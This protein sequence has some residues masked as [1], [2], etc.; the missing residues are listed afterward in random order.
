MIYV[1]IMKQQDD[2]LKSYW[3]SMCGIVVINRN[4]I[5]ISLLQSGSIGGNDCGPL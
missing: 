1:V 2:G 4:D 3:V 5:K